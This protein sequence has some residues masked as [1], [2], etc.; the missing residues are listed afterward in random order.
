MAQFAR[1]DAE[2]AL[3]LKVGEKLLVPK[4]D[5]LWKHCGRRK[6][7]TSFGNVKVGEYYFL[8]N[9]AHVKNESIYFARLGKA[10]DTIAQ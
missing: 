10:G 3:T 4:L 6:A 7:T 5:S 9:N 1:Y 8:G 2:F